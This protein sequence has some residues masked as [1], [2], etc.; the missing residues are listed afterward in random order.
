VGRIVSLALACVGALH[1]FAAE[2]AYVSVTADN[3]KVVCCGS[4]FLVIPANPFG[5]ETFEVN[6][7]ANVGWRL[8]SPPTMSVSPG[9]K[10]SYSVAGDGDNPEDSAGGD[11]VVA[12]VNFPTTEIELLRGEEEVIAYTIFPEEAKEYITV[13]LV[14]EQRGA[15]L[16]W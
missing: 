5:D 4:M 9:G 14:A 8:L 6:V 16:I 11:I 3:G 10:A 13:S 15:K 7:S 12:H 2:N 1:A